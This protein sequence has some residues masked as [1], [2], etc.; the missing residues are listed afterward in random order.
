M[1]QRRKH[2]IKWTRL[3]CQEVAANEVRLQLRAPVQVTVSS[4]YEF[5]HWLEK[6]RN[7]YVFGEKIVV[8]ISPFAKALAIANIYFSQFD[9][10]ISEL[11][12]A[13]DGYLGW[14]LDAGQRRLN[15]EEFYKDGFEEAYVPYS[16]KFHAFIRK[17][18]EFSQTEF[19]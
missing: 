11:D 7:V 6:N 4:L 12:R 16:D 13:A 5:S 2:A 19:K 18:K 9:A 3:S 15:G 10:D 14:M 1:D 8:G 17:L